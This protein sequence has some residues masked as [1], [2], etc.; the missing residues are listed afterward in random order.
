MHQVQASNVDHLARHNYRP[1]NILLRW[2]ASAGTSQSPSWDT[3]PLPWRICLDNLCC[4]SASL[5]TSQFWNQGI[6]V[7]ENPVLALIAEKES[8]W[9]CP[10]P[11]TTLQSV[12]QKTSLCCFQKSWQQVESRFAKATASCA[13]PFSNSCSEGTHQLSLLRPPEEYWKRATQYKF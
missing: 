13:R 7:L 6:C 4:Q 11:L 5:P 3:Q 12:S 1:W 9:M 2:I 10:R 8:L